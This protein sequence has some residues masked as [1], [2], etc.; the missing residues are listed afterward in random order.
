MIASSTWRSRSERAS[1]CS[2]GMVSKGQGSMLEPYQCVEARVWF[3]G[4]SRTESQGATAFGS[5][6][7]YGSPNLARCVGISVCWRLRG[8]RMNF[9]HPHEDINFEIPDDWLAEASRLAKTS[10]SIGPQ[11]WVGCVVLPLE[12]IVSPVR[13]CGHPS[14]DRGRMCSVL[15]AMMAGA[16]TPPILVRLLPGHVDRYSV[17]DGMHRYYASVAM[18]LETV[19]AQV[20]PEW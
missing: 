2:G 5:G 13:I 8:H 18:G 1:I 3:N 17:F 14:F 11:C 19:E 12:R 6:C 15:G 10:I 16:W 7:T 20:I 9:K 4:Q